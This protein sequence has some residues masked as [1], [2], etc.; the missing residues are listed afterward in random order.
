MNRPINLFFLFIIYNLYIDLYQNIL[1]NNTYF[2]IPFNLESF[3]KRVQFN[4]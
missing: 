2:S 4:C 3:L 1:L